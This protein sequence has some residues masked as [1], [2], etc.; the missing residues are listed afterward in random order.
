MC[1]NLQFYAMMIAQLTNQKGL[2]GIENAI[3]SNNDL[4]LQPF[5]KSVGK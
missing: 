2:R 3:A 1:T 5:T 4:K